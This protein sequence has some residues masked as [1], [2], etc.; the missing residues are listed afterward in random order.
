[1]GMR[2]MHLLICLYS[3]SLYNILKYRCKYAINCHCSVIAKKSVYVLSMNIEQYCSACKK[4]LPV[5]FIF[6]VC[7]TIPV[8]A[9]ELI[10]S[11]QGHVKGTG[12]TLHMNTLYLWECVCMYFYVFVRQKVSFLKSSASVLQ[13]KAFTRVTVWRCF[14]LCVC[15]IVCTICRYFVLY[16]SVLTVKHSSHLLWCW[17]GFM[18]II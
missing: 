9:C 2:C 7:V 11:C 12:H 4:R 3:I 8:C 15:R 18:R 1:M 6:V 16:F 13:L 5:Y 14:T 10:Q 17:G